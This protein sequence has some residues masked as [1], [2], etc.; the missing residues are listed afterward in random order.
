M[1]SL[2]N[3]SRLKSVCRYYI[4]SIWCP[5]FL[6]VWDIHRSIYNP[7]KHLW[8]T[9]YKNSQ[10][11]LTVKY[12]RKEAPSYMFDWVWNTTIILMYWIWSEI[13]KLQKKIWGF[14]KVINLKF[15]V[16][17]PNKCFVKMKKFL[18]YLGKTYSARRRTVVFLNYTN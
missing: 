9:F 7:A 12:F 10:L 3:F 6:Q 18:Y 15:G 13:R 1:T 14:S 11:I 17:M 8:G 4:D 2:S 16:F 5:Y